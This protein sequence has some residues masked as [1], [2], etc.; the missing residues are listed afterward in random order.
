MK[1]F[2]EQIAEENLAK[3]IDRGVEQERRRTLREHLGVKFGEV[4]NEISARIETATLPQL[5][6]WLRRLLTAETIHEVFE[7]DL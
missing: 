3:G 2:L 6:H 4:S 7:R 5:A 1:S